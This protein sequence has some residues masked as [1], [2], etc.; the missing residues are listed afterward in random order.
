M[1]EEV[2]IKR[3][4]TFWDVMTSLTY[5]VAIEVAGSSALQCTAGVI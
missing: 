1:K 3:L 4:Y 5:D 2:N